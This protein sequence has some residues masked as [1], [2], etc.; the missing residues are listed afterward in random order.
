M[1][2][3]GG[4]LVHSPDPRS[5]LEMALADPGEPLSLRPQAPRLLL[6]RRL[7]AVCLR[8]ARDRRAAGGARARARTI[9]MP[10]ERRPAMNAPSGPEATRRP[11]SEERIADDVF[12]AMRRENLARWPTG[13]D[14][15][16]DEAVALH[17]RAARAQ[18]ARPRHAPR[19]RRE[20]LPD[21]AARRLRHLR[22]AARTDGD[23]GPGGPRRHRADDH[24]QLHA[25][26]AVGPGAEG[27][28]GIRAAGPLDAQRLPDGQL[29][30]GARAAS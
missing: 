9:S 15:D 19:R 20:A 11:L 10:M 1:I 27:H 29:R 8:P 12:A 2:G 14:V 3:T 13:S 16:F 17:A 28:R 30:R 18:A 7:L 6:D 4:A 22:D 26:R 21:A 23:A 24:R 25:Q 5:V